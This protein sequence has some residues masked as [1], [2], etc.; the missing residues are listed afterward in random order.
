MGHQP[1]Q[2]PSPRRVAELID[3]TPWYYQDYLNFR[4][5]YDCPAYWIRGE[6]VP[7]HHM[8]YIQYLMYR[9]EEEQPLELEQADLQ[10]TE[11]ADYEWV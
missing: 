11:E 2:K 8:T 7:T 6:L 3:Q 10:L 5:E 1:H 9:Q 4:Q